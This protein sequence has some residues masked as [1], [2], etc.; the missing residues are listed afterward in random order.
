MLNQSKAVKDC[1]WRPDLL[2]DEFKNFF[3]ELISRTEKKSSKQ[4]LLSS[5]ESGAKLPDAFSIRKLTGD[6]SSRNYYRVQK[7]NVS[8][9]LCHD[10]SLIQIEN[11]H[12]YDFSN[13]QKLFC[14]YGINCPKIYTCDLKSGFLIQ[15]DLGDLSLESWLKRLQKNSNSIVE[16]KQITASKYREII[17]QMLIWQSIPQKNISSYFDGEFKRSFDK[18]KLLFE[19]DFFL[20]NSKKLFLDRQSPFPTDR[21]ISKLRDIFK[22]VSENLQRPEYFVFNH[23]DLH[24]RNIFIKEST[25]FFIDFQDARLGL[26]CYDLASLL[27]DSYLGFLPET[28]NDWKQELMDYHLQKLQESLFPRLSY[29]DYIFLYELSVF[30]RNVKAMGT[31]CFQLAEKGKLVFKDSLLYTSDKLQKMMQQDRLISKKARELLMPALEILSS[32]DFQK[33]NTTLLP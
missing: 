3:S 21:E 14:D 23:R 17:D 18:D 13:V 8:F 19:F 6:A 9:I 7:S 16:A 32:L 33:S 5:L 1:S 26:P 25:N 28:E 15:E 29:K 11:L 10:P 2:P 31:F 27:H 22:A 30:Q 12:N 4:E 24:S 20:E